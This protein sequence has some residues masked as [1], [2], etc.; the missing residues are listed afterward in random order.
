MGPACLQI[1]GAVDVQPIPTRGLLHGDGDALGSPASD[2]PDLMSRMDGVDEDDR[3]VAVHRVEQVLVTVN[4][5][6]LLGVVEAARH[7]VRLA[8]VKAQTMQQGDQ[9]RAAVA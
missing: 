3:L 1:D 5:S 6:L 9:P 7:G 2:W 8:I 4:E